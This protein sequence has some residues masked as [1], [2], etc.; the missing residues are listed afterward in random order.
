MDTKVSVVGG[1]VEAEV[2]TKGNRRPRRVLLSAVKADLSPKTWSEFPCPHVRR[3]TLVMRTLFA[4]LVFSF[5]KIFSDCCFVARALIL[6]RGSD[7]AASIRVQKSA[8]GYDVRS[9]IYEISGVSLAALERGRQEEE[10]VLITQKRKLG[11][12]FRSSAAFP[13]MWH[14]IPR[15]SLQLASLDLP[16]IIVCNRQTSLGRELELRIA[17][18]SMSSINRI[19][20]L[21]AIRDPNPPTPARQTM[22]DSR[23]P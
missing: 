3:A 13:L 4:C 15:T 16:H 19:F 21:P 23:P 14:Q 6:A 17:G 1:A 12:Q 9:R 8:F 10:V 11:W 22:G 2:D 7:L 18:F 20:G 5:S